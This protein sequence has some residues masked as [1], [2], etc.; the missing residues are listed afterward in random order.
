MCRDLGDLAAYGDTDK[1]AVAHVAERAAEHV[2]ALVES[3]QPV[4]RARQAS[5]M[6]S[7]LQVKIGR[8]MISV[9]VG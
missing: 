5:E 4:P 6:P 1:D 9:P 8:A 7:A 3:G 2:R